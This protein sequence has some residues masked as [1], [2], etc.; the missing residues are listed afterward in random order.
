MSMAACLTLTSH[1]LRFFS[2]C[3][4]RYKKSYY[5]SFVNDGN[6]N[7][8][9]ITQKKNVDLSFSSTK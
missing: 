4:Y 2:P 3:I 6:D 1:L 7:E 5:D 8:S 9:Y